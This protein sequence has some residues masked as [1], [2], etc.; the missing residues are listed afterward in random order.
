MSINI[1]VGTRPEVIKTAPLLKEIQRRG[2]LKLTYVHTGQHYDWNMREIFIKRLGLPEPLFLKVGSASHGVQTAQIIMR[3]ERVFREESPDVVLVE[4]DTNSAL[5]ASFAACKLNMPVAHVEAGCRS[6]DRTMPEEIN[7]IVIADLASLHFAPTETCV[8]NLIKEGISAEG[9]YLTGH[10]IS[11]LLHEVKGEIDRSNIMGE[12]S[13]NSGEYCLLTAHRPKNVDDKRSLNSL[14]KAIIKLSK[15]R[16][17]I[18]PVH[19]RALNSIRKFRLE[20]L[21]KNSNVVMT[22]PVCYVD[23]LSLIKNAR[24]VLTDSGGIQQEAA[25]LKTPCITL[26]ENT[27]WVETVDI[28]VNF[29]VG[30]GEKRIIETAELI[31]SNYEMISK[32]FDKAANLYGPPGVSK[33]IVDI[34]EVYVGNLK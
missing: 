12:L 26:R 13:L 4:G 19:P 3:S 17:V 25:L 9:I 14:L 29:L 33:K 15:E 5:G 6:F 11:D 2:G 16:T 22:E 30:C 20:A 7:R 23:C 24:M 21:L 10:P 34:V 18:F 1:V 27:E 8:K 32:R 31:E 28:G